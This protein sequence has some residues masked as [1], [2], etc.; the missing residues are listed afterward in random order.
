M[1][2]V[3]IKLDGIECL[4]LFM[5]KANQH[6]Y[7]IHFIGFILVWHFS[8]KFFERKKL[9]NRWWMNKKYVQIWIFIFFPIAI[10]GYHKRKNYKDKIN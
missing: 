3:L 2:K 10:Y 1:Q 9:F 4:R 7:L 6:S 8:M 5:E